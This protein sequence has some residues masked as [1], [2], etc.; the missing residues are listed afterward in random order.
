MK[1]I[2]ETFDLVYVEKTKDVCVVEKQ[3]DHNRYEVYSLRDSLKGVFEGEELTYI[4]KE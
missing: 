2:F 3:L 1:I 4:P